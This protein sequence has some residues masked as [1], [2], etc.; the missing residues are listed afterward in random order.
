LKLEFLTQTLGR[1]ATVARPE[2]KHGTGAA[3]AFLLVMVLGI[4]GCAG[5][6]APGS[7]GSDSGQVITESAPA[8]SSAPVKGTQQGPGDRAS[9]T[10]DA[11]DTALDADVDLPGRRF[12]N[13]W[14]RIRAGFAM[15]E[16]PTKL[17]AEKERFYLER[18]DYLDRM[19]TRGGRYLYY[20]VEEI[21]KRGM[22]TEL[23]LL[24]FVES[25][26]NPTAL[27]VAQASGLWQ[28]IPST[29]RAFNLEQDWWVDN[30]RDVVKSTQAALDYLQ[31]IYEMQ[32][33][34]WFLALASYNWGEGAVAR[35][36]KNNQARGRP[37]DYLSLNMP[38]ETRHYVPKLIALK[39]ILLRADELGVALP[40]LPNRPYFVTIEKTRPIDLK[41]A[42]QFAGMTLAE[43]LELNP[44][45]NRPVIQASRNNQIKLPAD[46]VDAFLQAV[47][48]H[49]ES[50]RSFATWHPYTLKQGETLEAVAQRGGISPTE[51]RRA[52]G[53]RPNSRILAGTRLLVPQQSGEGE[54][55]IETFVA[56][57]IYEQVDLAP[58]HHT[59]G[60]KDKL[61]TIASR[62]GVSQA[63]LRT[64]NKL[65]QGEPARGTRLLIRPGGTQTVL[66]TEQ[67]QRQIVPARNDPAASGTTR[68][69]LANTRSQPAALK[70]GDCHD[71]QECRL[72]AA[73][74][75]A[76]SEPP[77]TAE[78]KPSARPAA[79]KSTTTPA[80]QKATP[81]PAAQ[82]PTPR[83]SAQPSKDKP[84]SADKPAETRVQGSEA[85]P[86]TQAAS[87][88]TKPAADKTKPA[89]A[90][91][92]RESGSGKS[93]PSTEGAPLRT[94]APS[95]GK[96][97]ADS[98]DKPARSDATRP[99]T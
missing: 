10:E 74:K 54:R 88:A 59:V 22:P 46:R 61:A 78:Q 19:M 79:P 14:D 90:N 29:G 58:L 57:R 85:R 21:E 64:Q 63:Q 25:A 2:A 65:G 23:A 72:L 43:F 51:L 75:A 77:A 44:A 26:M 40:S 38:N 96:P 41:L 94:S 56:P 55:Q 91:A 84:K 98:S 97:A 73:L 37:T 69:A 67:G 31:K 68:P 81:S 5:L 34:D 35:A 20:I 93:K 50:N 49:S 28:F 12:D 6:Q 36:M 4:S 66:I 48:R 47:E 30:R 86:K 71:A 32:G 27:S 53:L 62:Y 7:P 18:R 17:V 24:P 11:P 16:L 52:N 1:S 80:V 89:Q 13:V 82:K 60:P 42:A 99:Q 87:A 70:A 83:A 8:A 76:G 92:D 45:H 39:N 3:C 33:R 9:A 95:A 15:P